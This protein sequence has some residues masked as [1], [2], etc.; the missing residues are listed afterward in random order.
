M[1][2]ATLFGNDRTNKKWNFEY[3]DTV[4]KIYDWNNDLAG[5]FF[6]RYD[7]VLGRQATQRNDNLETQ[8]DAI[9][10]MN[11]HHERIDGGQLMIPMVKLG[12]LDHEEGLDLDYTIHALETSLQRTKAWKQW[13][14]RNNG[15]FGIIGVAA[16]TAREDR[17]M[18][19]IIFDIHLNVVLG[20][21]EIALCLTPLL[22]KL[23]LDEML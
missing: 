23:H 2:Q 8:T 14:E 4:Y 1:W 21:K 16:Y 7:E 17:N 6:P 13:L 22:N 20:E 15:D 18:L 9:D 11:K 3:E 19:T 10:K 5:Y 12:L